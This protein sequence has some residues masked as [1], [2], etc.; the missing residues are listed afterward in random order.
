MTGSWR[1]RNMLEAQKNLDRLDLK[2]DRKRVV[3]ASV[4]LVRA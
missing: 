4:D 2:V 3:V 1:L